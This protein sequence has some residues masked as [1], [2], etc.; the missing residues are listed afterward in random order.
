MMTFGLE[1]VDSH[2]PQDPVTIEDYL[3]IISAN[4]KILTDPDQK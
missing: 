3:D 2:E 1:D 4:K